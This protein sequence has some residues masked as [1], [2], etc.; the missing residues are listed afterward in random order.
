MTKA[1]VSP[2]RGEV[3]RIAK[4]LAGIDAQSKHDLRYYLKGETDWRMVTNIVRR[5]VRRLVNDPTRKM[6]IDHRQQL[7]QFAADYGLRVG[8]RLAEDLMTEVVRFKVTADTKDR[9]EA[10]ASKAG[11]DLSTW[12][13]NVLDKAAGE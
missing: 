4:L 13:R 11:H 5:C 6:R 8:N 12:A 10:A 9:Y 7:L 2:G 1:R 3:D